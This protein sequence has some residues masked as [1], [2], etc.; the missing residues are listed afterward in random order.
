MRDEESE[1]KTDDLKTLFELK[2]PRGVL[3]FMDARPGL[4]FFLILSSFCFGL[5]CLGLIQ[6]YFV[7]RP[8]NENSSYMGCVTHQDDLRHVKAVRK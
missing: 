8:Q 3:R 6:L 1:P 4:T 2:I 7:C 5:W